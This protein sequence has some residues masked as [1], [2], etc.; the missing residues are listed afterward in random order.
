MFDTLPLGGSIVSPVSSAMHLQPILMT[1]DVLKKQIP[2]IIKPLRLVDPHS[3]VPFF[4][5]LAQ[6]MRPLSLR[7]E[8]VRSW[9][10]S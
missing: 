7:A 2:V 6:P 5:S 1:M 3:S 8:E 10:Q 4:M 9:G